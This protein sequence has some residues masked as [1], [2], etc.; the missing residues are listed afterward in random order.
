[1][2]ILDL[3]CSQTVLLGTFVG[4]PPGKGLFSGAARG[5]VEASSTVDDQRERALAYEASSW[6]SVNVNEASAP[7]CLVRY[8]AID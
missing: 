3:F 6:V 5:I 1:M 8:T 7:L 2:A 4:R